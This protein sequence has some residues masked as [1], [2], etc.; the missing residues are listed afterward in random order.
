MRDISLGDARIDADIEPVVKMMRPAAL[1]RSFVVN[2]VGLGAIVVSASILG[3]DK[4]WSEI[5]SSARWVL[6]VVLGPG[7]AASG[8]TLLRVWA[9]RRYLTRT[10]TEIKERVAK[11]WSTL[12]RPGWPRRMVGFGV[13]ASLS[14]GGTMGA[15]FSVLFP[16]ERLLGSTL[17]TIG[18]MSAMFLAPVLLM[19]FGFRWLLVRQTARRVGPG[20][21]AD[22]T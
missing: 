13:V 16:G 7:I 5:V 18:A 11:D 19:V 9:L 12:T 8:S 22:R 1:V 21:E 14:F 4:P 17:G 15:L 3:S 6:T 10:N 2:W 20:G